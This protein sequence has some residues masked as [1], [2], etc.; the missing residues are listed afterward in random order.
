M[1]KSK[2]LKIKKEELDTLYWGDGLSIRD[3]ANY[4]SVSAVAIKYWMK[5]LKVKIRTQKEACNTNRC[6]KKNS[7]SILQEKHPLWKGRV[8]RA[9]GYIMLR[10]PGKYV[11]EHR[12]IVEEKIGRLLKHFEVVHHINRIRDDNRLENLYVFYKR[13][14]DRFSSSKIKKVLESNINTIAHE[15]S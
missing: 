11:L 1:S 4:F 12:D 14:H 10:K 7:E 6:R 8:K 13:E 15:N 9:D 3:I 5:K 2:G